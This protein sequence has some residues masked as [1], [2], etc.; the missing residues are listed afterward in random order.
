M[1]RLLLLALAFAGLAAPAFAA[2]PAS[3][4]DGMFRKA[5]GQAA[6]SVKAP[7]KVSGP[8][9]ITVDITT[10]T[11][12]VRAGNR[13]LYSF[14]VSTGRKGYATPTGSFRPTRMHEM[15]HSSQYENAPMPYSIFFHAGYAIHG[16]TEIARLGHV[17]S[18]GCVRLHPDNARLLFD[19][20]QQVGMKNTR[21]VLIRS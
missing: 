3:L 16:T 12:Q 21:I 8:L 11:M 5:P 14:D 18:H 19:L 6:F 7:R 9:S 20:V 2:Q 13:A 15:W 4:F 10:Q 1:L 17:A